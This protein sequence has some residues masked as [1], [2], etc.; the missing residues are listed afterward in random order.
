MP[1]KSELLKFLS[2]VPNT[3]TIPQRKAL[4]AA[5]G[6]DW[7]VHQITWEGTNLVFFNE[8]L[9]LLRSEGQINL[10][11]FLRSLADRD[12]NWV[13]LENGQKL[14]TFAENISALT[15]EEWEREFWGDNRSQIKTSLNRMELIKT[16]G[17]L[18]TSDFDILVFSLKV[19]TNIIPPSTAPPGN[20]A[21]A[22]LQWAE[23]PMGCG[24]SDVE[25]NLRSLLPQ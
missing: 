20:R 15:P 22:L 6:F 8:L 10:V 24:L 3:Q 21:F 4:L 11:N 12:L 19:P 1:L 23:S 17:Q 14:I 25:A 2:R 7:L 16:L 18:T 9:E 5:V 13:G